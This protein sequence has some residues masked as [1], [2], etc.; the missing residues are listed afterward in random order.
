MLN[1]PTEGEILAII[2]CLQLSNEAVFSYLQVESEN[3]QLILYLQRHSSFLND[4]NLLVKDVLSLS[5]F[6][7]L[8]S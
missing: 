3:I 7:Y 8:F 2:F 5:S 4:L 6:L 1:S